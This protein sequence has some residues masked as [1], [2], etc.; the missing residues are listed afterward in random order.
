MARVV[1][2]RGR[3]LRGLAALA[4][5]VAL[6]S[7][8]SGQAGAAPEGRSLL[9]DLDHPTTVIA[10]EADGAATVMNPAGLG[11][12]RG[13]NGVVEA[14]FG[15]RGSGRRG[16]GAGAFLGVPVTLRA[17]GRRGD[18]LFSLGAGYQWLAGGGAFVSDVLR[19]RGVDE[20]FQKATVALAV[21]LV[22]WVAGLGVGL[23]YSH[24][25]SL[26]N[27]VADGLDQLDVGIS[28][29]PHAAVAMGLV[30][31]G[32]NLAGSGP[33]GEAGARVFQPLEV[34]PE[35]ALRPIRGRSVLEIGIGGRIAAV[36]ADVPELRPL[37]W[38]PRVRLRAQRRGLGVFAEVEAIRAL[39]GA[40]V[41]PM[42]A[43][44]P[45]WMAGLSLDFG[46]FGA[47]S[48]VGG[49]AGV[50]G[51]ALRLRFSA[52][53][54]AGVPL[55]P[56]DVTRIALA[57]YRGD[58]GLV[59]LLELLD[60]VPAT[61]TI[62]VETAGLRPG[63]ARLEEIREA[64]GR[65][66]ARGGTVIAYMQGGGLGAYYVASAAD[67]VI[68]HPLSRLA[69][70][71][72]RAEVFYFQAILERL[73][74]RGEF[75]RIAEYKG[76]PEQVERSGASPPVAAQRDLL[77]ADLR[78]HVVAAIGVGRGMSAGTVM[79]AID[80]APL[81]PGEA[82]RRGLVD[83]LAHPDEIEAEIGRQVGRKVVL[84]EPGRW[85][86]H[87]AAFREGP[88]VAVLHV[89]GVLADGES[90]SV[91]LVG[92]KIAGS[93]TLCAA[94]ESLREDR[95]VRA[96]VV[97]VDSIG[98]SVA[99]AAAIARELELTAAVKPV[100]FS[101]GDVAASGG[102]FIATAS[103]VIFTDALTSTGS[104]GVFRPKVDLSGVLAKFG[105]GVDAAGFGA[106]AGI[107]SWYHPYTEVERAAALAGIEASYAD[108]VGRV[109]RA[110]GLDPA[111]V[112]AV[113][114]GRVWSGARALG[115]DLA[116][117][118][119]GLHEAIVHARALA[120]LREDRSEVV[121]VPV[122]PG[123]VK[124]LRGLSRVKVPLL[125]GVGASDADAEVLDGPLGALLRHLPLNL[126][127][128]GGDE[129]LAMS[130]EAIEFAP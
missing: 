118:D 31:R 70:V 110:R 62:L 11:R 105:I 28:Y 119:G 83:A 72:V 101:F 1:R 19:V 23:S 37:V 78:E 18:A 99:A 129:A 26:R 74:A 27:P 30:I 4:V 66:R 34:D 124:S 130:A 63:W 114:R 116:D 111:A 38:Q 21:P 33:V 73:G 35:V 42:T 79:A 17:L 75:L 115:L 54:Y 98:G 93:R 121:H 80:A 59:R 123:I 125:V 82:Q 3:T 36:V 112:D 96:V 9:R 71:G 67:R 107:G 76:R 102:Y 7:G 106:A 94:I 14:V 95:R 65:H 87:L 32:L 90:F 22:R 44:Q 128:V 126:W 81:A 85:A 61:A 117:H 127:L 45:R 2:G 48:G 113:A 40:A 103:T 39:T 97:R 43:L 51:G 53:R 100:V 122:E 108:F 84:R 60:E 50:D 55:P 16:A 47:A 46:R 104:I 68:A 20:P 89:E 12:L 52:E 5:G 57:S 15:D 25:W 8:P 120:G 29:A 64:L 6:G 49:G 58:R 13:V 41:R 56:R 86:R 109:G 69:I 88:Q 77:F 91:P 92:Q 10:G 24:L